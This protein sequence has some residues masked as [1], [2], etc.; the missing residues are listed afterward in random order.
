MDYIWYLMGYETDEIEAD[1]EQM[2]LRHLLHKQ[3]KNSKLKLRH[4][5]PFDV[6][7][8]KRN[9]NVGMKKKPLNK[10]NIPLIYNAAP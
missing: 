10:F 3:I 4:I 9:N 6:V 8:Y 2:R 7:K 1:P 5:T